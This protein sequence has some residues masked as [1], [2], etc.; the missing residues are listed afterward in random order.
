[1]LINKIGDSFFSFRVYF[2][3]WNL[4]GTFDLHTISLLAP[5]IQNNIIKLDVSRLSCNNIELHFLFL[6][7][8]VGKS[9][10]IRLTLHGYTDAMEDLTPVSSIITCCND[11]NSRN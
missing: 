10:T 6:C 2:N 1:M 11:G 7:A 9:D 5:S 8:A 3:L 4:Y